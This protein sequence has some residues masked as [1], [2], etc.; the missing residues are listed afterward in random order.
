M[1]DVNIKLY[2]TNEL[3]FNINIE[4]GQ[5][6]PTGPIGITP[7][8]TVVNTITGAPNTNADVVLSGTAENPQLTFTIPQGRPF[9]VEVEYP[10]ITDLENNTNSNPSPYTPTLFDLAIIVS[11]QGAEDPDNAKLYIRDGGPIGGWSFVSDLSGATG[12]RRELRW[13]P[14]NG[15]TTS[16]LQWRT[17]D[18]QDWDEAN[19]KDLGLDFQFDTTNNDLTLTVNN[20]EGTTDTI[21]LTAT[22]EFGNGTN[23]TITSVKF[24]N[25]NGTSTNFQ[26]LKGETGATGPEGPVGPQGPQGPIGNTGPAGPQG[27]VGSQG[28]QGIKGDTGDKGD[29]GDT[30]DP[31][32]PQTPL[33]KFRDE[34]DLVGA[35]L[36]IGVADEIQ[37][38]GDSGIGVNRVNKVYTV[39]LTDIDGGG[40]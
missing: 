36:Q 28:P 16:I 39:S 1:A 8:L 6:G 34:D 21:N 3:Q 9:I 5:V 33:F 20:Y 23:A 19:E 2:P 13:K 38:I 31:A 22:A 12:P 7:Q 18:G 11:N 26:E 15:G 25:N 10:S 29:K 24:N 32:L 14:D 40:F 37:F 35:G 4:A 30:G 27:E 17:D